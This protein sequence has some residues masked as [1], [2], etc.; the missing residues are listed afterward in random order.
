M[1]HSSWFCSQV[2]DAERMLKHKL[3]PI[4]S[5]L[6]LK[7]CDSL[8]HA[9]KEELHQMLIGF[10]GE[11]VIPSTFYEIKETLRRPDLVLSRTKEG[12]VSR[13]AVSDAM[14]AA[15]YIRLRD[16]LALCDSSSTMVQ[17][18][19]EYASHFVSM[20]TDDDTVKHLTGNRVRV[21]M[22]NLPFLLRDLIK[23]EVRIVCPAI[24][25]CDITLRYRTHCKESTSFE[26]ACSNTAVF[27]MQVDHVNNLIRS[28]KSGDC[29]FG[30]EEIK[31]PSDRLIE[32]HLAVLRYN[33]QSRRFGL[34]APGLSKLHEL[35]IDVLETVKTNMPEK[36]EERRAWKF[37][38]AHSGCHSLLHKARYRQRYRISFCNTLYDI[39]CDHRSERSSCLAGPR[40]STHKH[41]SIATSTLSRTWHVAPT[42]RTCFSQYSAVT[43]VKECSS[44]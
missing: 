37:E 23:P 24:I 13:Y 19:P 30:V 1:R 2:A 6:K 38:K 18:S 20:H 27:C 43:F 31:D 32:V 10:Y 44:T 26:G 28:A 35:A 8:Q 5:V 33:M 29:L 7:H 22:L 11:H 40:T 25:V 21:L 4:S 39:A 17:V 12:A 9:P 15:V 42:T 16:R 36:R 3:Y 14:L 34:T 41:L